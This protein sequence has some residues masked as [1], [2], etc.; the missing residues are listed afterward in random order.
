MKYTF[1][2][3]LTLYTLHIYDLC[4]MYRSEGICPGGRKTGGELSGVAKMTGFTGTI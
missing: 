3:I 4:I 2:G 1:T